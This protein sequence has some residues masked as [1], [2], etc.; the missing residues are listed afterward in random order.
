MY[1]IISTCKVTGHTKM[2]HRQ[3]PLVAQEDYNKVIQAALSQG[4]QVIDTPGASSPWSCCAVLN[5]Q[6]RFQIDLI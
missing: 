4:Y 3:D 1:T 6:I 5:G 2:I